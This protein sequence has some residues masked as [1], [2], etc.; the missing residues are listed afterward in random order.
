MSDTIL[1]QLLLDM[2][3]FI[4]TILIAVVF[5]ISLQAQCPSPFSALYLVSQSQIDSFGVKYDTCDLSTVGLFVEGEE[6][7]SLQ[8]LR[9]AKF[10]RISITNTSLTDLTGLRSCDVLNSF[11]IED[12]PLL[13]SFDGLDSLRTIKG[14]WT[15]RNNPSMVRLGD[16]PLL[17]T[18][19]FLSLPQSPTFPDL[20]GLEQV[21]VIYDLQLSS[22]IGLRGLSSLEQVYHFVLRDSTSVTSMDEIF[23]LTR[24]EDGSIGLLRVFTN[25]LLD[26]SGVERGGSIGMIQFGVDRPRDYAPLRGID[27][28]IGLSIRDSTLTDLDVLDDVCLSYLGISSTITSL[29]GPSYD[30][31]SGLALGVCPNLTDISAVDGADSLHL[32]FYPRDFSERNGTVFPALTI[33]NCPMLSDCDVEPICQRVRAGLVRDIEIMGNGPGCSSPAEVLAACD[34]VSTTEL[35]QATISLQPNPAIDYMAIVGAADD[36]AWTV[37][38]MQGKVCLTGVG[39]QVGTSDLHPGMYVLVINTTD[40]FRNNRV[41]F[42]KR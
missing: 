15:I 18:I 17:D 7:N 16:F 5:T 27:Y 12:N 39:T 29:D 3:Y 35:A 9:D 4:A 26:L 21:T 23:D 11:T 6:I 40:G 34:A 25:D 20:S 28:C 36:V 8:S 13:E 22:P 19:G 1:L 14:N 10:G 24:L 32:T 38:N 41:R 31:L 30:S 37:H 2:R 42:I 33:R